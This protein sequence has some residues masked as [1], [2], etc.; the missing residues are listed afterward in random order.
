MGPLGQIQAMV[1]WVGNLFF[2]FY[3]YLTEN[4]GFSPAYAAFLFAFGGMFTGLVTMV[5][6]AIMLSGKMKED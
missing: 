2:A 6:V 1:F 5:V 3:Y 4:Q